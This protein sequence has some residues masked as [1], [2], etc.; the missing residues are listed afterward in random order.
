[1][2]VENI[3]RIKSKSKNEYGNMGCG[4]A[5][6]I[7]DMT[8]SFFNSVPP[9]RVWLSFHFYSS[10]SPCPLL[11]QNP[12]IHACLLKIFSKNKSQMNLF[13]QKYL[14]S[15]L[16]SFLFVEAVYTNG[17]SPICSTLVPCKT[18]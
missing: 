14:Q 7:S 17:S 4:F 1:M 11:I 15:V 10:P 16:I 18:K 5:W 2:V 8:L 13:I 6:T 9:L 12:F 3:R